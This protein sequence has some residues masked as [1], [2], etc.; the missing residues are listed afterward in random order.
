[1]ARVSALE[2]N[3]RVV[4]AH[5]NWQIETA[6]WNLAS[7]L[8][9]AFETRWQQFGQFLNVNLNFLEKS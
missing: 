1:M 3:Y 7:F 8:H 5:K 4:L 6:V 2:R 9:C